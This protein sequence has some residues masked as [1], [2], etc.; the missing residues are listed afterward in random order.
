MSAKERLKPIPGETEHETKDR[1]K[2]EHENK[3]K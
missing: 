1:S 3:I 2:K